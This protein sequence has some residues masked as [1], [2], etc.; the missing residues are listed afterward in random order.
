MDPQAAFKIFLDAIVDCDCATAKQAF[1]D[2]EA[3]LSKGGFPPK[4]DNSQLLLMMRLTLG[5]AVTFGPE[6]EQYRQKAREDYAQGDDIEIDADAKVS[7]GDDP[8]AWVQAWVWVTE[9]N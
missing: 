4:L 8:G 1:N 9:E 7:Q 6:D 5:M 2:L 3:W